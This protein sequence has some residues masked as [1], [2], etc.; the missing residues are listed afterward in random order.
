MDPECGGSV[1]GN[2]FICVIYISLAS[3][4]LLWAL[5]SWKP[6]CI[7]RL[8]CEQTGSP[9]GKRQV[10]ELPATCRSITHEPATVLA[11]CLQLFHHLW[12]N[13]RSAC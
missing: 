7:I 11:F 1:W 10:E 2:L 4:V 6:V 9:A 3:R 12:P 8:L 5:N 13:P